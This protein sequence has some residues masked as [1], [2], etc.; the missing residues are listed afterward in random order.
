MV[1]RRPAPQ[2][3]RAPAAQH[4]AP[5]APPG[6]LWGASGARRRRGVVRQACPAPGQRRDRRALGARR[7]PVSP[8]C[9][10]E[11]Q[12]HTGENIGDTPTHVIMVEM[13]SRSGRRRSATPPTVARPAQISHPLPTGERVGVRGGALLTLALACAAMVQPDAPALCTQ[14]RAARRGAGRPGGPSGRDRRGADPRGRRRGC[15]AQACTLAIRRAGAGQPA[16]RP[17]RRM[18]E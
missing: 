6:R 2:R 8:R 7:V 14:Q 4:G 17:W 15:A 11:A 1:A 5:A 13:K 10:G 3:A 18:R 9:G 12:T 16:F